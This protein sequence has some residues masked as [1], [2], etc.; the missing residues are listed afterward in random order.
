MGVDPIKTTVAFHLSKVNV[1]LSIS[2]PFRPIYLLYPRE[3]ETHLLAQITNEP[4]LAW[5]LTHVITRQRY[6]QLYFNPQSLPLRTQLAKLPTVKRRLSN[7]F[8]RLLRVSPLGNFRDRSSPT[9]SRSRLSYASNDKSAVE[10]LGRCHR[11]QNSREK[12]TESRFGGC[13]PVE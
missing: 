1:T 12:C 13:V 9:S 7:T 8:R 3:S 11:R 6:I 4:S 5:V 2:R 10:S